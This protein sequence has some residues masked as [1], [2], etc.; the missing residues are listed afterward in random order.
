MLLRFPVTIIVCRGDKYDFLVEFYDSNNNIAE[1]TAQVNGVTFAGP[2][3]VVADGTDAVFTGSMIVGESIEM[4]GVN[5]AYL[6]SVGYDGFDNI[7]S[8]GKGGFL[9]Y[10][11][12]VGTPIGAS[13]TYDGVG[14]EI[15][16]AHGSQDRYLKFGTNPS[17]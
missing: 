5:P 12:S 11:G 13:E 8:S 17:V 7:I 15:V 9:L 16:D 10:S 4:Y 1:T 3:Q 2:R 6:R 14:L